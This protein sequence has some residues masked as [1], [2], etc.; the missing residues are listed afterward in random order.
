MNNLEK[1]QKASRRFRIFFTIIMAI[2]PI[3]PIAIILMINELPPGL[4]VQIFKN[5]A[6]YGPDPLSLNIRL[7]ASTAS[8]IPSVV[9]V[10]G[11]FYL[12]K[13]FKYYENGKIF[14][15]ENVS[16]YRKIGYI[17]IISM[18]AGIVNNSLMSMILSL[19]NPP[20]Q[21]QL[22]IGLS[23]NDLTKLVIGLLIILIS[24]IMDKGREIQD[25][26]QYTI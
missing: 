21:R 11:F 1:I 12:I 17:L 16:C 24:W 9:T 13:L 20:G 22:A 14:Y 4:K 23:S 8:L 7:L 10:I 19:N 2:T 6:I 18:F 25:E 5:I 3:I 26:Q 15:Q